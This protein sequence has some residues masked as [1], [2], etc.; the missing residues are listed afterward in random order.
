MHLQIKPQGEET[1]NETFCSISYWERRDNK[2]DALP[3]MNSIIWPLGLKKE[4]KVV[5]CS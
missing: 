2:T 4:S 3:M 1:E 5:I